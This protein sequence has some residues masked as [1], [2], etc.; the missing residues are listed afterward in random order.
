MTRRVVLVGNAPL[1]RSIA[2]R[3]D[4][5]DHVVRFNKARGFG[6]ESGTRT[7][8]LYLVNHGGQMAE[9]LA[10]DDLT[11]H[12]A[13]RAARTIVLPVPPLPGHLSAGE[14]RALER[15]S[16]VPVDPDRI[17]HHDAARR[18]LERAGH[19]VLGVDVDEY[20][21]A[22]D[23]LVGRGTAGE[24]YPSTG[25]IA[26]VRT[27]ARA[28]DDERVELFGFTF[29]GWRGHSWDAEREWVLAR[30]REGR[31]DIPARAERSGAERSSTDRAERLRPDR[32]PR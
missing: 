12:P 1:G 27:V 8:E 24:P 14:A 18:L 4:A 32:R 29:E 5:A 16:G 20:R 26:I 11:A 7:D 13:V 25:F 22:Q 15:A 17:N 3:V 19:A 2:A 23:A 31:L 28:S 21:A 6:A 9:W 30:V 10:E